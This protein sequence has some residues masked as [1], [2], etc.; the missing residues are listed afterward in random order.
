MS[1]FDL[2][3]HIANRTGGPSEVITIQEMCE[4]LGVK[5]S[6][7]YRRVK[8]GNFPEPWRTLNGRTIGWLAPAFEEW[9]KRQ[10]TI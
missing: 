3:R 1:G 4:I 8:S 5:R 9:K 6:T 7:L 10:S 2:S